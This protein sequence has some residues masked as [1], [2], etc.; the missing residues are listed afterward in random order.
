M[1]TS[2]PEAL[3]HFVWLYKY[4]NSQDLLTTKGQSIIIHNIGQYHQDAG[5]DFLQAKL[6]IDGTL[7]A[8]H[9][10]M[11]IKSGDWYKHKHQKDKQYENVILHVVYEDNQKVYYQNGEEI[12]CLVLKDRIPERIINNYQQ[13]KTQQLWIPCE[14]SIQ[15]IP[16]TNI[17]FWKHRIAIERLES[18]VKII[19]NQLRQNNYHWEQLFYE[20]ILKYS[21]AK[22]NRDAFARLASITPYRL[23]LKNKHEI[24]L[25]ESLLLGQ[26]SFLSR[27][28][29]ELKNTNWINNYNHQK[30]KYNLQPMAGT[31]WKFSRLRPSNF[32][33]IR[34]ALLARL[35]SQQN[36]LF[37]TSMRS[38]NLKEIQALYKVEIK[39]GFWKTHYSLTKP[40]KA[41]NKSL[42]KQ[43]IYNLL[44][45]VVIPFKFIYSDFIGEAS[46]REE[47]L[48]LLEAL[49]PEQNNITRWWEKLGIPSKSAYDSQALI[50][51]KQKYCEQYR[52][53]ECKIG[54]YIISR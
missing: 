39:D 51:L 35:F 36:K 7:W 44:I 23:I 49:A 15:T 48:Q 13:L 1:T 5:P 31:Y 17:Q 3:L 6:T 26:A 11:H 43:A 19:R 32:P 25:L 30:K 22:V 24:D 45:N 52:C 28:N 47:A 20:Y 10:E 34:I 4:F 53:L 2:I 27:D 42:G 41:I 16:A 33:S 38:K 29:I 37:S 54:H 21:S 46:L 18:K 14:Q 9:I 40:S 8:G 50:H 12:P